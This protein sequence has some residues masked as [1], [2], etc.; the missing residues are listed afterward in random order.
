MQYFARQ[1][2]LDAHD[3]VAARHY[4]PRLS[5]LPYEVDEDEEA[6]KIVC[7]VKGAAEPLVNER[8]TN[9]EVTNWTEHIIIVL[10]IYR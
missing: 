7:L 2:F 1:A 5:S 10:Y 3:E 6:V 4:Q 9:S 8:N